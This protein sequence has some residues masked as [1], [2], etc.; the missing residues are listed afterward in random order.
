M[1]KRTIKLIEKALGFKLHEWQIDYISMKSEYLPEDRG[2][3]ATTAF[4][5]RRLLNYGD[6]LGTYIILEPYNA[7]KIE[8]WR[9]F[10]CDREYP[11]KYRRSF[12][13]FMVIRLDRALKSVGIDTCFI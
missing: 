9:Q 6:K 12:Y 7:D 1:S 8:Y 3:G 5:L 11:L 2:C 13:M 10:P 4:I